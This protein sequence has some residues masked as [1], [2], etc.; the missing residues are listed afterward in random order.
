[1]EFI[2]TLRITAKV[3]SVLW[4][5]LG[6]FWLVEGSAPLSLGSFVHVLPIVVACFA[7][8]GVLLCAGRI[9]QDV[10]PRRRDNGWTSRLLHWAD[11][12]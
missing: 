6:V 10:G 8:A 9:L 4:G 5:G 12:L 1:M 11:D 2:Q 3:L 7:A